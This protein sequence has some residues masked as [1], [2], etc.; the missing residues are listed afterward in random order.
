M[1]ARACAEGNAQMDRLA[2]SVSMIAS[3]AQRASRSKSI[4]DTIVQ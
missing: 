2:V 1:C 3:P 4:A